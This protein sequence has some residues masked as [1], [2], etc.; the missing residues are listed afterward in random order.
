MAFIV[1]FNITHV[2]AFTSAEKGAILVSYI[3]KVSAHFA[4]HLSL[5]FVVIQP[6]KLW[7]PLFSKSTSSHLSFLLICFPWRWLFLFCSFLAVCRNSTLNFV[8]SA[9]KTEMKKAHD[10][11]LMAD[12]W[13]WRITFLIPRPTWLSTIH[14]VP[15][16]PTPGVR[17]R[18]FVDSCV[19]KCLYIYLLLLIFYL[20]VWTTKTTFQTVENHLPY[21]A[22]IFGWFCF[23]LLST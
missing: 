17:V 19:P 11:W 23:F 6:H 16:L 18:I 21:R 10:C 9:W 14:T 12:S 15:S 2:K 22:S 20:A 1:P 4:M 5:L 3:G 7:K 8:A 13:K